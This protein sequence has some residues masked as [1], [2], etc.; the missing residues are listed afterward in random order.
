V[1][2]LLKA[3]HAVRVIMSRA[4]Q[5]LSKFKTVIY[6]KINYV[7]NASYRDVILD[8]YC[9]DCDNYDREVDRQHRRHP[10]LDPSRDDMT[11]YF[12]I[13]LSA[14]EFYPGLLF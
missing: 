10:Q 6:R 4:T 11:D 9:A 12:R 13:V 14:L 7:V 2:P 1:N 8:K 5:L 3:K